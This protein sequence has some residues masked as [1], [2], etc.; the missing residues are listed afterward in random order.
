MNEVYNL[1]I[2]KETQ[3]LMWDIIQLS[4]HTIGSP[5]S[6]EFDWEYVI[7]QEEKHGSVVGFF[8]THPFCSDFS[9]HV[10]YSNIDYNTMCG[11][12]DCF[13]KPLYCIIGRGEEDINPTVH[14]FAPKNKIV[15]CRGSVFGCDSSQECEWEVED[16]Y[17]KGTLAYD[18]SLYLKEDIL[19]LPY[20]CCV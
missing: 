2:F 4:D 15:L 10:A 8:H 16:R 18:R 20:L 9:S 13:G 17:Y 1:L 11:W 7:K 5:A 19:R 3:S 12:V 14:V 6:V